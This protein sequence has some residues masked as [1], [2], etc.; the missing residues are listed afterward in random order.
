MYKL[1]QWYDVNDKVLN[2]PSKYIVIHEN[3]TTPSVVGL[4]PDLEYFLIHYPYDE[5]EYDP[6][7]VYIT[8]SHNMSDET[9]DGF[10][11]W[12]ITYTVTERTDEDKKVSI[13]EAETSQNYTIINTEKQ[14]KYLALYT[15]ITNRRVKGLNITAEMEALEAKVEAKALKIWQNHITA[16][17]KKAAVDSGDPINIDED[18]ET[19]V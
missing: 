15:V 12:V 8:A 17:T 13:E 10:R 1:I 2:D 16:E 7:L 6:R 5:P 19:D 14:L 4:D 3:V 9:I 11:T 18:W